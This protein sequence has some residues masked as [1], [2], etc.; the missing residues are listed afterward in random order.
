MRERTTEQIIQR[1]VILLRLQA[2][3]RGHLPES[4]GEEPVTSPVVRYFTLGHRKRG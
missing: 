1:I 2:E 3:L 4:V